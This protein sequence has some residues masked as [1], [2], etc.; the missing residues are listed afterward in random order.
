MKRN[1]IAEEIVAHLIENR[2]RNAVATLNQVIKEA[3]SHKMEMSLIHRN[4]FNEKTDRDYTEF[5]VS[6]IRSDYD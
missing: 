4:K 6:W 5:D 1:L 2:L 3:A